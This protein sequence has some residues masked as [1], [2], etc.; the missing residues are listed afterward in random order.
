MNFQTD[1]TLEESLGFMSL[2]NKGYMAKI[3]LIM[4]FNWLTATIGYYALGFF[5][6]K[7]AGD[8]YTNFILTALIEIPS[9]IFCVLVMDGFGRKTILAFCQILAGTTCVAAAFIPQDYQYLIIALTLAGNSLKTK[10]Y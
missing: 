5:S 3:S 4:I 8:I 1:H 6:V 9:Y 7:L 10:L 2:F